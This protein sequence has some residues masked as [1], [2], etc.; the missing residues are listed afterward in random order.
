M[1]FTLGGLWH[2]ADY[3]YLAWGAFWGVLLAVERVVEDDLGINTTPRENRVLIVL[4]V[5]FM[6]FLFCLGAI[7]FRSQPVRFVD[8]ISGEMQIFS[9]ASVMV[10]HLAGLATH[11]PG[12]V[13]D[14]F[15]AAGGDSAYTTAVFGADVF[16]L[17]R[18]SNWEP[19]LFMFLG[20]GFFHLVQYREG[21]FE[22][23]RRYDPYLLA[24]AGTI[25]CGII[26]P[27]VAVGSHSFIYFVF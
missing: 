18:M 16:Q 17:N 24:V 4:K 27:A 25:V 26:M 12:M 23:W 9:S 10:D 21:L 20:L 15:V 14:A 3:T 19:I 7:M 6:F 2:C 1:S 22:Q 5:A 8:S 11:W 13:Y